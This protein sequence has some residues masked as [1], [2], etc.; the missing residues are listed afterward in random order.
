MSNIDHIRKKAQRMLLLA[1]KLKQPSD[2]DDVDQLI[3]QCEDLL[4]ELEDG[5]ADPAGYDNGFLENLTAI[6]EANLEEDFGILEI[7]EQLSISR[8]HL[9]R[10]VKASSGL[11][12][13]LYIRQIRLE[14]AKDLL[15]STDLSVS[16]VAYSVGFNNAEYFSRKFSEAYGK[17]PS[18]FSSNPIT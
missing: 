4:D 5:E 11:S 8:T 17:P 7:C 15:E 10:K 1:R 2:A 18:V 12:I 16:Q 3:D 14:K 13:S 6:I 9:H